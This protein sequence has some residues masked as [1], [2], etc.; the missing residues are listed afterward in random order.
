MGD[1]ATITNDEHV[2]FDPIFDA[3]EKA[4]YSATVTAAHKTNSSAIHKL[5]RCEQ[6]DATAQVDDQLYL[7]H[8]VLQR[9]IDRS[10]A[11]AVGTAMWR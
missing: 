5:M 3:C 8:A 11:H 9:K 6:V 7:F 2:G 1:N 4:T 10:P